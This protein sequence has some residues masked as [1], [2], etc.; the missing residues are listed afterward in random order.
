MVL[1]PG[2]IEGGENEYDINFRLGKMLSNID[3]IVIVGKTNK[4][5]LT[6]GIKASEN[7]KEILYAETLEKA[8]EYFALLKSN[9]CLLILNDLPDDYS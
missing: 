9:D 4:E 2:I 3:Y 7:Y 8:K 6:K 1:T 5:A